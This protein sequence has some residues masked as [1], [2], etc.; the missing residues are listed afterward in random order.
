MPVRADRW[1]RFSSRVVPAGRDGRL[2]K[3]EK[4]RSRNIEG[5]G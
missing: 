3:K 2:P 5:V 4:A 1:T